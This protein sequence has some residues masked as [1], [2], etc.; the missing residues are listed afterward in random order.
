MNKLYYPIATGITGV[1][2]SLSQI[3]YRHEGEPVWDEQPLFYA[4]AVL[5]L[6]G[7]SL[8]ASRYFV[9]PEKPSTL[10]DHLL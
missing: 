4:S 3:H 6:A 2:Y 1:V 9:K 8:L 5:V 10:D 7:T